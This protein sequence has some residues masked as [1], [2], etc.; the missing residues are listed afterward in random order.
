VDTARAPPCHPRPRPLLLQPTLELLR[1]LGAHEQLGPLAESGS[2]LAVR[3]ADWVAAMQSGRGAPEG[4]PGEAS[5]LLAAAGAGGGGA[6]AAAPGVAQQLAW[7][8]SSGDV[9][10]CVDAGPPLAV[11]LIGTSHVSK[12]SAEDVERAVQVR[13][14]RSC[15]GE[16]AGVCVLGPRRS[17]EG[18]WGAEG[19]ERAVHARP[20]S[21]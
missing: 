11:V 4:F 17:G 1:A 2:L 20:P 18:G 12:K 16:A 10:S 8:E 15:R 7:L 21:V 5:A 9:R 19:V 6:A 14:M 3:P 13:R